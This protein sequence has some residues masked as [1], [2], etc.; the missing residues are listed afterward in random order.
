M[1]FRYRIVS[2][3]IRL[4]GMKRIFRKD[5]DGILEFARKL[6][7]RRGYRGI[8]KRKDA[9]YTDM[10]IEG[11][12]CLK[13]VPG[14]RTSSK[15][16][17]FLFG[18]GYVMDADDGDLKLAVEIAE[19]SG[20]EVWFPYY[21]LCT[22]ASVEETYAMAFE[23]YRRML[24]VYKA[25]DIAFL[26]FSSGA[27]LAIGICLHNNAQGR[28][29]EMP[30]LIIASSP[31]SIPVSE[32]ELEKMEQL[33]KEDILIDAAF[34]TT[35]RS[36][37]EQGKHVPLY[38]LS[39]VCGDFSAFPPTYFFYGSKEVLY[40][41]AEFFARAYDKYGSPYKLHVGEGMCHCYPAFPFIP[42]GREAKEEMIRLL[43]A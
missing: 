40:A 24:S 25:E 20:R 36:I 14:G 15:A 43:K 17:L 16:L 5:K 11:Y 18:G 38:M 35:I 3:I 10:L 41:E 19:A 7:R 6:N 21:P 27:A 32:E 23:T 33:S 34:M 13:A 12:H 42:E 22:S 4:S 28:P 2:N 9:V 31:G 30:S 37:M 1:S 39:G 26:G 8:P 29:L